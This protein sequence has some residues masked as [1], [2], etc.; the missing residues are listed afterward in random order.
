[1]KEPS[2]AITKTTKGRLPSLPFK[3]IKNE[4]VGKKYVLS[5]AFVGDALSKRLHKKYRKKDTPTNV[6]SFPLSKTEGEIIINPAQ[7][8]REYKNFS[9]TEKQYVA[10]LFIHGLLHLKGRVHGS[11]MEREEKTILKKFNV[12]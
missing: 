6:L 3:D 12:L 1:M 10:Y 4:I 11:T 7:A 2:F 5:L 8:R 9:M